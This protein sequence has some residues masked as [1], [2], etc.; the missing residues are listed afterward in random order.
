MKGYEESLE[1]L[2]TLRQR[3][4]QSMNGSIKSI[5]ELEAIDAGICAIKTIQDMSETMQKLMLLT[6]SQVESLA[7]FLHTH[8]ASQI[9]AVVDYVSRETQE[10]VTAMKLNSASIYGKVVKNE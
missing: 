4:M 9:V 6:P 1:H 5:K 2:V 8:S 7:D 10:T 3:M